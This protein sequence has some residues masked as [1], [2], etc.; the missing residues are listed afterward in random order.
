MDECHYNNKQNELAHEQ[1]IEAGLA[2]KK[3]I[4]NLKLSIFCGTKGFLTFG[5][6]FLSHL[7]HSLCCNTKL[8]EGATFVMKRSI[9]P[10]FEMTIIVPLICVMLPAMGNINVVKCIFIC[11]TFMIGICSFI[12]NFH[13][14]EWLLEKITDYSRETID[15]EFKKE[16]IR[17]PLLGQSR[18]DVKYSLSNQV[19]ESNNTSF[20][21]ACLIFPLR[22]F[23]SCIMLFLAAVELLEVVLSFCIDLIFDRSAFVS[24]KN[25]LHRLSSLLYASVSNLIPMSRLD[26][27]VVERIGILKATCCN[28]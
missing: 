15:A 4:N 17:F 7:E 14:R 20:F 3:L 21:I 9:I 2:A 18:K 26:G 24:T 28:A 8:R 23:Q 6:A 16:D 25:N 13:V 5:L 1:L 22:F 27:L 10:F 19:S 11:V 12:R